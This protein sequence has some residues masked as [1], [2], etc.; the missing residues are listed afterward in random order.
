MR[1]ALY[2]GPSPAGDLAA[3]FEAVESTLSAAAAMKADIA[4]F[5]EVFLPGYNVPQPEAQPLDGDWV[6]RLG[7]AAGAAGVALV[8][9]LAEAADGVVYNS[10]VVLGQDGGLLAS[11][12]KLQLFG[13]REKGLYRPGDAYV[14]FPFR[15]HRIGLLICYDVEFPEHV[16][17]IARQGADLVLVPTA[18]MQPFDNVNRIAIPARA[19]ENGVT[20]A[21]CNYCG[22]EGELSYVGR[23]VIAGPDGEPIALAGQEPALLIADLPESMASGQ[24]PLTSTLGDLRAIETL[25]DGRACLPPKS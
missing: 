16:R 8:I 14:V 9:G 17:A 20:L 7:T 18:N 15:N 23:S 4:L 22:V 21:Y 2:Q 6:R 11:F 5:P 12:R 3:A 1:L 19:M 13:E 25:G 24:R 10:A